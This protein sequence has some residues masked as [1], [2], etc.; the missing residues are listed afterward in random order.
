MREWV[1]QWRQ[2]DLHCPT[3]KQRIQVRSPSSRQGLRAPD[4]LQK[5]TKQ[6]ISSPSFHPKSVRAAISRILQILL[7]QRCPATI[8]PLCAD[9]KLV[10]PLALV[11]AH[12]ERA[13]FERVA[14]TAGLCVGFSLKQGGM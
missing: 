5:H 14:V 4:P 9:T 6:V 1:S 12:D 11:P 7:V 10:C 2:T 13:V 8:T 3:G